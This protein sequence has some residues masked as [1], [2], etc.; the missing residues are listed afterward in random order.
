MKVKTTLTFI[1]RVNDRSSSNSLDSTVNGCL[2]K[3]IPNPTSASFEWQAC[4]FKIN[5]LRRARCFLK[6]FEIETRSCPYAFL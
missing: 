2:R 6:G 3:M 5:V 1:R 4:S